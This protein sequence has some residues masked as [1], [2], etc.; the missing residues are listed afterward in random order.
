MFDFERSTS[1]KHSIRLIVG[2]CAVSVAVIA[3]ASP[4]AAQSRVKT[5]MLECDVSGGVGLI[6]GSRKQ[7]TC[8]FSPASGPREAYFGTIGKFGLD[9]G[10][11][12]GGRMAWAVYA[13]TTGGPAALAG[14]YAGA[15]GEAT[16]GAGLGANVLVGGSNRTIALQPVSVQGQTGLNLAV[17]VAGLELRPVR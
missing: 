14:T 2:V 12:S 11:T 5:G 6:V 3:L 15:S 9:I 10:A 13:P 4:S 7:M 1:M 8:T 16:V 17:G